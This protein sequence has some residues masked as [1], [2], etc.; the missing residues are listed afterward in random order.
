[1]LLLDVLQGPHVHGHTQFMW[2]TYEHGTQLNR[3]QPV[4]GRW[5][6]R[7]RRVPVHDFVT[8]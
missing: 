7:I 2:E 6:E 4:S 1:M 5:L 3:L 8:T